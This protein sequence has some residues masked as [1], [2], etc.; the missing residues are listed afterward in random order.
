MQFHLP[1]M[2]AIDCLRTFPR[3]PKRPP[4]L[5]FTADWS[6]KDCSEDLQPLGATLVFEPFDLEHLGRLIAQEFPGGL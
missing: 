6:L 4:V 2:N 3:R 5:V 1:D